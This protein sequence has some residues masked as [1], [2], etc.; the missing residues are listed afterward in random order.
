MREYDFSITAEHHGGDMLL[1]RPDCGFV[2]VWREHGKP[3]CT[4]I[5]CK[6][7]P[8]IERCT[9]LESVEVK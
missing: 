2:S 7:T 9:C 1:H 5:G 3:I 8:D 6:E 4:L